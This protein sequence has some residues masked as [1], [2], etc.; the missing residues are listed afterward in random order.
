MDTRLAYPT[1]LTDTEW[2]I[3]SSLVPAPAPNGRPVDYPRR[4]IVNALLYFNR[5]GCSWRLLPHDLPP[6]PIVYYYFK[7]WRDNGTWTAIH[8]ALR[9]KVRQAPDKRVQARAAMTEPNR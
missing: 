7:T 4:E 5:A 9:G 6:Y 2:R 8:D 1:D 3:L